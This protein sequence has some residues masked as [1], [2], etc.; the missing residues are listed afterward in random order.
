VI[1]PGLFA[2]QSLAQLKR[3]IQLDDMFR[4]RRVSSPA[5][6]PDGTIIVYT[7]TK[8][9][10]E[11]NKNT[12][13]LWLVPG[14]GGSA[15]QLTTHPANDRNAAWSPDGKWIAFESNR[16]G[17]YQIWLISPAG[18]EAKQLTSISTEAFQPVWSPDSRTIGFVSEVFP[19]NSDKPFAESDALNKARLDQLENG[20]V[21]AKMITGLLYRHW[22]GWVDGKRKHI[23]VQ[24]VSGGEPKD[25]TPGN[26]DAV[27]TSSTFSAGIDYAFSPDGKE[28][29]YTAT[30]VPVR[31]EAWSTNH[32]IYTVAVAGG[33]PK[34]I[35]DNPAA[36][37]YPRYSPDGRYIAYRAQSVPGFEADRWQMILLDR[38]TGKTRRLTENL[39]ASVES[40]LWSPD[41]KRLYFESEDRGN[42]P[43]FTVSVAGGD[44]SK[45]LDK[46]TNNDVCVAK[47]GKRLVFTH[48]SA[49]RPAELYSVTT[50][51]KGLTQ[52]TK[53]NDELFAGLDLPSPESIWFDGDG[54]TKIQ[55]WLLKPPKFDPGRKYPF[56]YLVHG[57]P[58]GAWLN[59]W[60]Y[61][62]NPVLW[63]AQGYVIMAPNPRGSTGFGQ[64][65][66]NEISR[67][68]GGKVFRDLMKGLDYAESLPYVDKANKAAAGASYGGYMMNWFQGHAG[69]RFKT[70]VTH[71]GV[72]NFHSMYGT[73]EEIWF[74]EWD[75]GGTPW[76][77]PE[78]YEQFSPHTYAKNFR[79]PNLVIHSELDYRVPFSEGMQLFTVLQRKGI[80]SK[81]LYFPDEGHL[82]LKP[83]NSQL[84][85]K[86]VFDWLAEYLKEEN[87]PQ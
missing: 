18:G 55:S 27:P 77:N 78:A 51:G 82:I 36:D 14:G 69:D 60:S 2:G 24:P 52:I 62:W 40:A 28:I 45:V 11:A 65:F 61:R 35:T 7:V 83:A 59:S 64:Q 5:L 31:E 50:D 48:S 53:E 3:P 37:G 15:R 20:K 84:W 4:I 6:A 54:G 87:K 46:N 57:G 70:L 41:S 9:D 85:H 79:T 25:L 86:T 80:P 71:S 8:S 1:V 12:S 19:E 10:L 32:D 29:A 67:D 43:I 23:F 39:D 44:A 73:T 49:V 34:Q 47:D 42:V 75:H 81:L 16:S 63:A 56:I 66:T 72:Y 30:P 17:T 13:D 38:A 21:K 68:W 26:R 58:Q 76:D 33:T 74:D 22:D